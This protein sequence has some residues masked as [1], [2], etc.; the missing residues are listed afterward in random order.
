[1]SLD[2][3][4]LKN[5]F[6]DENAYL[7]DDDFPFFLSWSVLWELDI[8]F[9]SFL[10]ELLFELLLMSILPAVLNFISF[11]LEEIPWMKESHD[12]GRPFKVVITISTF[13]TSSSTTSSCSLIWET[14]VKYDCMVYAFW[15]FTFSNWFL[16][17]IF[18]FMFF[19][20]NNFVR[21]SNI[22]LGVFRED[23]CL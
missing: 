15:I 5:Y 2:G 23:K 8:H 1:M 10:L 3:S 11:F 19:P 17:V 20:W 9:P 13:S 4:L 12:L 18:Q 14:L 22:D 7:G 6:S 21:E 16:K